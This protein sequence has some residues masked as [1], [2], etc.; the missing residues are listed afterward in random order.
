MLKFPKL[1]TEIIFDLYNK[2][3]LITKLRELKYF[4]FLRGRLSSYCTDSDQIITHISYQDREDLIHKLETLG[5]TIKILKPNDEISYGK[6]WPE[7]INYPTPSRFFPD[8]AEPY[9]QLIFDEEVIIYIADKYFTISIS[10]SDK[11]KWWLINYKQITSAKIIEK[12]LTDLGL[13]KYV[14]LEGQ[15][16]YG[17]YI[18]HYHYPELFEDEKIND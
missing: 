18:N 12:K 17:R 8:I 4:C 7:C 10:N 15:I 1:S 2:S 3:E 11:E 16:E 13:D 9:K 6:T 5:V 14:T